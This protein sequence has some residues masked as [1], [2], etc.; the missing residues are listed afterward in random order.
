MV[1][2]YLITVLTCFS[3]LL[4][5]IWL[6]LCSHGLFNSIDLLT[7]LYEMKLCLIV[8]QKFISDIVDLYK[9][10]WTQQG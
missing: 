10:I 2:K 8:T 3:N 4:L 9:I 1:G 7:N 6:I 5:G